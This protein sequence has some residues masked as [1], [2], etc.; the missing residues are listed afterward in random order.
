MQ[1]KIDMPKAF[2]GAKLDGM[3]VDLWIFS[4]NLYFAV[5]DVPEHQH[6][7]CA[8]LNLSQEATV[9]LHL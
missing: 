6:A 9:W 3:E 7:M 8:A 2:A 1:A 4:M 5:L